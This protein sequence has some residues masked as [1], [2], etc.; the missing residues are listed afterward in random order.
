MKIIYPSA[1]I[2]LTIFAGVNASCLS[3]EYSA[4]ENYIETAYRTEYTTET[5]SENETVIRTVSG[6]Y[7]LAPLFFWSSRDLSFKGSG[8]L[9]Y[10]AYDVPAYPPYD[11][12]AIKVAVWNQLQY[13][14]ANIRVFD[15][16]N[17][18]HIDTPAPQIEEEGSETGFVPWTWITGTARFT[19]LDSANTKINQAMF[20]GGRTNLWSKTDNPQVLELNAGKARNIAIIITGPEYQWNARV[21]VNVI[22]QLDTLEPRTVIKERQIPRQ[23]PYQVQKQKT[24]NKVKQVPF[25][26]VLLYP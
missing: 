17:G 22:W 7:E 15:M 6:E 12:I 11:S 16:T 1:M 9:W 14:K 3:K 2:L 13:E 26:E 24:I 25:W 5:Y 23:V 21:T 18:G 10:Y 19:W 8:N 4:T 20:L